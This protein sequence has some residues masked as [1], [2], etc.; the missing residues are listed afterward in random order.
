VTR[1]ALR[2]HACHTGSPRCGRVRRSGVHFV[3]DAGVVGSA[4]RWSLDAWPRLG[5]GRRFDY[6]AAGL[7][8]SVADAAREAAGGIRQGGQQSSSSSGHQTGDGPAP[9]SAA[10]QRCDRASAVRVRRDT[11][12]SLL[13]R[14]AR[15]RPLQSDQRRTRRR[16]GDQRRKRQAGSSSGRCCV[17][18]RPRS[19]RGDSRPAL[20]RSCPAQRLRCSISVPRRRRALLGECQSGASLTNTPGNRLPRPDAGPRI[21]KCG[22]DVL[23][24]TE[25]AG[26]R[27]VGEEGDVVDLGAAQR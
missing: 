15:C 24:K 3:G 1:A 7:V 13:P 22:L 10:S 16:V 5:R 25:P 11:R 18:P 14:L 4:L 19:G 20:P 6:L 8:A 23:G 21:Q 2:F 12:P 9:D 27:R 26:Q 17:G